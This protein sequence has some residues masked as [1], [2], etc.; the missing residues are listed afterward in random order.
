MKKLL[1][2]MLV[3]PF[4]ASSAAAFTHE[5]IFKG[6]GGLIEIDATLKKGSKGTTATQKAKDGLLGEVALDYLLTNNIAF[7]VSGGYGLFKVTNIKNTKKSSSFVPLTGTVMFRL[8][9]Y[10]KFFPYI[11]AGYS[12]KIFSGGPSGTK[13]KNSSGPVLQAGADIFFE[14]TNIVTPIGINLDVKYYLKSQKKIVES[15]SITSQETFPNKM[16]EIT[17]L[18]GIVVPF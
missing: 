18:V 9:V 4:L 17:A 12:Y 16:S 3:A 6:R 10:N 13:I 5:F 2:S 15:K 11:G 7:E 14:N 8:P 1:I